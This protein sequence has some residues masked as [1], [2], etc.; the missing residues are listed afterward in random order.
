MCQKFL[1]YKRIYVANDDIVR[2]DLD[3]KVTNET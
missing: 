1:A 3:L 2:F